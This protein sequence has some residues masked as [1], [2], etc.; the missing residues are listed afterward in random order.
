MLLRLCFKITRKTPGAAKQVLQ[1]PPTEGQ[2][3][4]SHTWLICARAFSLKQDIIMAERLNRGLLMAMTRKPEREVCKPTDLKTSRKALIYRAK[5]WG[6]VFNTG[7]WTTS[8]TQ[9]TAPCMSIIC[10]LE[11]TMLPVTTLKWHCSD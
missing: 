4:L 8:Q 10:K 1:V 11:S 2:C 3:L 9:A 5:H 7:L 6:I